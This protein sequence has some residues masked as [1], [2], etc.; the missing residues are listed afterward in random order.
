MRIC[1]LI[2]LLLTAAT[3]TACG[4]G[5]PA[6][7]D[8]Q[9]A[10][11]GVVRTTEGG[12][13]A[14]VVIADREPASRLSTASR[15]DG[16]ADAATSYALAQATW[17]A[18]TYA[19]QYQRMIDLAAGELRDALSSQRPEA[20]QI[21][22]IREYRQTSRAKLIAVDSRAVEGSSGSVVVVLETYAGANGEIQPVPRHVIYRAAVKRIDDKW[23]VTAFDTIGGG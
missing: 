1:S 2:A 17:S 4:I 13:D 11:E 5:G 22:G 10:G 18:D 14:D 7:D 6:A 21:A 23:R 20:D 16:A 12:S 9:G 8:Q 19:D 3:L 15:A